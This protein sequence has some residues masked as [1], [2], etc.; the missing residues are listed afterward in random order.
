MSKHTYGTY[1][2]YDQAHALLIKYLKREISSNDFA[3]QF[4]D[5]KSKAQQMEFENIHDSWKQGYFDAEDKTR[6]IKAGKL[7]DY[8]EKYKHN[9][10]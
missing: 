9:Y 6:L 5:L 3:S 7:H 10:E 2:L 1:W 8:L 4:I